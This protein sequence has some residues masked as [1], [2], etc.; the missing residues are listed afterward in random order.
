MDHLR[1]PF[2]FRSCTDILRSEVLASLLRGFILKTDVHFFQARNDALLSRWLHGVMLHQGV[3]M[4]LPCRL[5][6]TG[7]MFREGCGLSLPERPC[8]REVLPSE[9]LRPGLLE[10]L[11]F[12]AAMLRSTA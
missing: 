6:C 1:E 2:A 8:C 3:L 10:R 4:T 12:K 9:H 11:R 5:C 7:A